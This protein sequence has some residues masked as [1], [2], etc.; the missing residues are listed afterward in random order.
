MLTASFNL[1]L[2]TT[3][4]TGYGSIFI[5]SDWFEGVDKCKI[6]YEKFRCICQL[7]MK[8]LFDI[9]LEVI[10]QKEFDR[11]EFLWTMF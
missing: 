9:S 7:F 3:H 5:L 11:F 8:N 2:V 1:T 10:N 4:A 6:N